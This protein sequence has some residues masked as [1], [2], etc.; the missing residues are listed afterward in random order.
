MHVYSSVHRTS[1]ATKI[2][3]AFRLDKLG[4]AAN[5]ILREIRVENEN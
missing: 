4:L 2:F 1:D 3:E 5:S